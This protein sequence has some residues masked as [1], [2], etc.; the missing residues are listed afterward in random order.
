VLG[1]VH[2]IST[3]TISIRLIDYDRQKEG[4]VVLSVRAVPRRDLPTEISFSPTNAITSIDL[5]KT[6]F[7]GYRGDNIRFR[8]PIWGCCQTKYR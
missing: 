2:C 1:A 7:G 8:P 3:A 4:G 6:T 5:M